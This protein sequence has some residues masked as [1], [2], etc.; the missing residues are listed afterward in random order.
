MLPWILLLGVIS[1]TVAAAEP[2]ALPADRLPFRGLFSREELARD[3]ERRRIHPLGEREMH[4]D[5][6]VPKD[7]DGR[8]VGISREQIV[9]DD[10]RSVPLVRL[11]PPGREDVSIEVR[12]LRLPVEEPPRRAIELYADQ[13]KAEI[14]TGQRGDFSGRKVDDALLEAKDGGTARL[15]RATASR[16]GGLVFF[17][18]G[19]APEADYESFKRVLATAAVGFLPGEG[20]IYRDYEPKKLEF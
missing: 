14:L 9:E 7:W 8:P 3:F 10:R 12:Y 13:E 18:L 2:R 4:I 1:A 6:V 20:T 17:V 5:V 16:H 19:S 15:I 11:V